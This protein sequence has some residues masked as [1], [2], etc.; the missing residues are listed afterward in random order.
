LS[1]LG[2]PDKNIIVYRRK[3]EDYFL[4]LDSKY[5]KEAL[6]DSQGDKISME[7]MAFKELC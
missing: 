5:R 2:F 4:C 3:N 7:N 6:M 1:D